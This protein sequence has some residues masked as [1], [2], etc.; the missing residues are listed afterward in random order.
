[1]PQ[2]M[3]LGC[4]ANRFEILVPI[5]IGRDLRQGFQIIGAPVIKI[6]PK[7]N[8]IKSLPG[9]SNARHLI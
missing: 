1:M 8:K 7:K 5:A 6:Q 4:K 3:N 9:M 2:F